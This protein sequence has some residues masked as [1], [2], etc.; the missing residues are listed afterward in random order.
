MTSVCCTEILSLILFINASA[1][2]VQILLLRYSGAERC[3]EMPRRWTSE[4]DD[5]SEGVDKKL[6]F[7]TLQG[8]SGPPPDPGKVVSSATPP[9]LGGPA[10]WAGG[11][12]KKEKKSN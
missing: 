6:K 11:E 4:I 10:A 7:T 2:S 12:K 3:G 9:L 1:D 5:R 8:S